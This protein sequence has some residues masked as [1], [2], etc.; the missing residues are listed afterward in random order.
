MLSFML[1]VL[2]LLAYFITHPANLAYPLL[3]M[4][5]KYVISFHRQ[6]YEPQ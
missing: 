5:V 6:Q 4:K 2:C 1:D 3:I